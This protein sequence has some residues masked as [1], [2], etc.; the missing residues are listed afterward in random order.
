MPTVVASYL[1]FSINEH[2]AGKEAVLQNY[3]DTSSILLPTSRG[4]KHLKKN[5]NIM[6]AAV[7][8]KLQNTKKFL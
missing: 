3:Q 8:W 6:D 2:E 4:S 5:V 1:R 7:A